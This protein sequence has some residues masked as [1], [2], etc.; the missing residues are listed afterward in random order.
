MKNRTLTWVK[1]ILSVG[2]LLII[3]APF[4][5][6]LSVGYVSFVDT[7]QI[8]DTI[9]GT[10]API[11]SLLGSILVFYALKAQI[12]ANSIIQRQLKD[13]KSEELSRKKRNYISGQIDFISKEIDNFRVIEKKS[14]TSFEREH[15]DQYIE[16][17]GSSAI[18]QFIKSSLAYIGD[19]DPEE[20]LL[21]ENPQLKHFYYML[22]SF[23]KVIESIESQNLDDIDKQYFLTQL[24]YLF[25]AKIIPGFR[26][27]KVQKLTDEP[28][29]PKCNKKHSGIPSMIFHLA[30]SISEKLENATNTR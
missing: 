25:E 1:I 16:Y 2:I 17:V 28:I 21:K 6:T 15:P 11:A 19:E 13:Q 10:T 4:L 8:G 20:Q 24:G 22:L 29:C 5:L 9:G 7:G 3:C 26:L 18:L 30:E 12:D 14:G 27:R 23:S